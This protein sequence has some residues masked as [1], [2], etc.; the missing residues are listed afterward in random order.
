M[1]L[2]FYLYPV[3]S[4]ISMNKTKALCTNVKQVHSLEGFVLKTNFHK[5]MLFLT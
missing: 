4:V 2:F 1:L 3:S 5:N